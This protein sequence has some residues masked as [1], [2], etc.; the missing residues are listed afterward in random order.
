MPK[1][2]YIE[3]ENDKKLLARAKRLRNRIAA[4]TK[5]LEGVEKMIASIPTIDFSVRHKK[6]E[7]PMSPRSQR[8][9]VINAVRELVKRSNGAVTS[10]EILSYLH[11][12]EYRISPA[13]LAAV[14]GRDA[15]KPKSEIVRVA[16][17]LYGLRKGNE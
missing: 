14:L 13:I 15:N 10:G 16:R 4:D 2:I 11:E 8:G 7:I 12:K 9:I 5:E 1:F 6:V 17:G 3:R